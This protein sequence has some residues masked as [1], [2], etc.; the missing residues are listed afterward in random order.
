MR[1]ITPELID[2]AACVVSDLTNI[3]KEDILGKKRKYH[4]IAARH[5]LW[6]Y[7]FNH[8]LTHKSE[9]ARLV[10]RDHTTLIHG[11]RSVRGQIETDPRMARYV[12]AVCREIDR[13]ITGADS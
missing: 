1:K 10:G 4:F 2:I 7:L 11:L 6:H 12:D 13:R 3:S 9:L 5:T 8:T